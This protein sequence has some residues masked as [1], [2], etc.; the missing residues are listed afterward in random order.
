MKKIIAVLLTL[1]VAVF[2]LAACG[3]KNDVD[4]V[5]DMFKLSVPT[6]AVVSIAQTSG[7]VLLE[8]QKTLTTGFVGGKNA[9]VLISE[10]DR[11][12]SVEEAGAGD[13]VVGSIVTDTEVME[14]LEGK[15][16]RVNGGKWDSK[17]ESFVSPEGPMSL[18]L[19][20]ELIKNFEYKDNL[21]RCIV[22]AEN[23]AE[24]FGYA[25]DLPVSVSVE[26]TDDGAVITSVIISYTLPEDADAQVAE[27]DVT[28]KCF[29]FYDIQNI[30]IK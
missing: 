4:T 26:I 16:V 23:T 29:Y 3:G 7:D 8:T 2:A 9:A 27:T 6:K 19:S 12:I 1:S 30:E 21:L 14:Y 25:E 10:T 17:A 28:I 20:S 18:N 11:L 22:S 13:T 5:G 24:V 15:G